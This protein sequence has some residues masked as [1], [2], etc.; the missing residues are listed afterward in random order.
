[1]FALQGISKIREF[2]I[3]YFLNAL[4]REL[5]AARMSELLQPFTPF[6][7]TMSL[8]ARLF[9]WEWCKAMNQ[10]T[11]WGSLRVSFEEVFTKY[12][13][14][15]SFVGR[16]EAPIFLL[17]Y[18]YYLYTW[19]CFVWGNNVLSIFGRTPSFLL[20]KLVVDGECP[21]LAVVFLLR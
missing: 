3:I 14:G 2:I 1:M 13:H 15:D 7:L 9:K 21:L 12:S 17:I 20:M 10:H 6:A 19:Y 11:S 8:M 16:I 18:I 5:Q 4:Y